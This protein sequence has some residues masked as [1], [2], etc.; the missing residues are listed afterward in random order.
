MKIKVDSPHKKRKRKEKKE[1]KANDV[2]NGRLKRKSSTRG[3]QNEREIRRK[4]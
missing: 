2:I 1:I 4:Q 3:K